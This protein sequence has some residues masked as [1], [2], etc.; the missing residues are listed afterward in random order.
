MSKLFI[1]GTGVADAPVS[2]D[3]P[4]ADRLEKGQPKRLTQMLYQ[5]PNM[6]CG[7][8]QCEVGAWR[9]EFAAH[10]QEFFQIIEGV[11]RLHDQQGDYIEIKAGDAGVIPPNF[12][13]IFE[14][15]AAVRKYYVMVEVAPSI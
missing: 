14:V 5:H 13:G 6:E 4:R 11:V 9:I 15:I 8:W 2:V 7:I 10:K 12:K 1:A 3:Y